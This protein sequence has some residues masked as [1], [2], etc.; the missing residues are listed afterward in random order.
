MKFKLSILSTLF[1]PFLILSSCKKDP[2]PYQAPTVASRSAIA[3]T[4]E[5]LENN[6]DPKAQ[7]AKSWIDVVNELASFSQKFVVPTNAEV[8][9][10]KKSNVYYWSDAG[11]SYWMTFSYDDD[12]Y[13]WKFEY[14]V[15]NTTRI[16]L[17][18]ASENENHKSGQWTIYNQVFNTQKVWEYKWS[19]SS[20]NDYSATINLTGYTGYDLLRFDILAKT[21]ASGHVKVYHGTQTLTEVIWKADGSG[22][23]WVYDLIA[24][25]Y[26]GNWN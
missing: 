15:L 12:Q 6:P 20:S 10:E 14:E 22:S 2:E 19:L 11:I 9:Y 5:G 13:N 3:E 26:S 24:G 7:A 21:N 25:S 4:P 17:V 23:W 18:E 8:E 1:V 16:L